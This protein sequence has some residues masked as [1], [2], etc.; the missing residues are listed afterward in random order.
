MSDPVP[1][2]DLNT[3]LT[4]KVMSGDRIKITNLDAFDIINGEYWVVSRRV[5]YGENPSQSMMLRKVA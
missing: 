1:V 4:P 5:S 2:L 3:L